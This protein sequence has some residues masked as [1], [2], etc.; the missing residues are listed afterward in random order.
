MIGQ[1]RNV[2]QAFEA[3]FESHKDTKVRDFCHGSIHQLPGGV[4]AGNLCGPGVIV[5]LFQTQRNTTPF[6]VYRQDLA[7]DFLIFFQ[8]FTRVTDLPGPGHVRDMQQAVDPLSQLDER[9]VIGQ[10]SYLARYHG[11]DGILLGNV[12]PRVGLGLLH[13]QGN[14][15]LILVHTQNDDVNLVTNLYEF[16]GMANSFG[17]RHLA[18]VYQTFDAFLE[19]NE[20]TI[21]HHVYHGATHHRVQ[22]I[23]F[24]DIFPRAAEFLL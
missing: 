19:F 22:G 23:L 21:A 1:L 9:A 11:I 12:V 10:I 16:V 7:F 8:H 24:V 5:F 14:L 15:F 6:L 18:D 20:R 3:V 13:T 4:A 2:Q 17:P